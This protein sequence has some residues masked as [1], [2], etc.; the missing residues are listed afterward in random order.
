MVVVVS[1]MVVVVESIVVV[2]DGTVVVV[3]GL[4]VE[5]VVDDEDEVVVGCVVVGRLEVL[6]VVA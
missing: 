1:G 4:V 3:V 6:V 5:V 2:V